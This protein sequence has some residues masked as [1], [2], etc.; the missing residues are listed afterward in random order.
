MSPILYFYFQIGVKLWGKDTEIQQSS[1]QR[2]ASSV[3]CNE[4]LREGSV[5]RKVKGYHQECGELHTTPTGTQERPITNEMP[6]NKENTVRMT[7]KHI[8]RY[9]M[10]KC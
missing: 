8:N 4:A 6:Y 9:L 1:N 7:C 2:S 10:C 5:M 3:G